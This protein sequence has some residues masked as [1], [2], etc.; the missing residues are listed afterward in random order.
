VTP[1]VLGVIQARMT[2]TRFPGKVLAPFRG[3]PL[4]DHVVRRVANAVGHDAVVVATSDD[5]TDDPLAAHL[6]ARDVRCYRGPLDDVFARFLGCAQTYP[7]EWVLRVSGDSPLLDMDVLAAVLA[8]SR[9]DVDVV[10]TVAPRTVS[11]GHA[12]E[13]IRVVA[14]ESVDP[15]EL[16]PEDREHVTPFFYRHP[17]RFR[18]RRLDA[19]GDPDHSFV[20]DTLDDLRRLEADA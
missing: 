8:A 13:L 20:V 4:I 18:I 10:T 7:C 5:P 6:E 11:K 12:A 2:S 15:G 3:E 19:G 1:A 16:D 14:F 17:E 9:D